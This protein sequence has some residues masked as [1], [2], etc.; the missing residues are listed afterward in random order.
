MTHDWQPP[1]EGS[2][3]LGTG[4]SRLPQQK[5][6]I[7]VSIDPELLGEA[8][9]L[10]VNLSRLFED[11]LRESMHALRC[12]AW[13]KRNRRALMENRL[14]TGNDPNRLII[15]NF[16]VGQDRHLGKAVTNKA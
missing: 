13:L 5:K 11:H 6:R 15:G 16:F 7:N 2:V 14:D 10:E 9:A 3:V 12:R 4:K 8:R 1:S